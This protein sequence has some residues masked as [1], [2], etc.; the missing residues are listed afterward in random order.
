GFAHYEW[1][2]G[3]PTEPL[4][5]THYGTEWVRSYVVCH[6]IVDT[7]VI[8]GSLLS[9]TTI[10]A[11]EVTL[12]TSTAYDQYQWYLDGVALPGATNQTY[13][14]TQNGTYKVEVANMYGCVDSASHSVTHMNESDVQHLELAKRVVV[15]PNPTRN[16][17][18]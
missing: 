5:V 11:N 4:S 1:N 2:T 14:V 9:S 8:T 15:Y 10:V 12:S 16:Y 3:D 6:T 7:F 17:I 13:V 18:S